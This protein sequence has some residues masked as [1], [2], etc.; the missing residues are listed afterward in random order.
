MSI[1]GIARQNMAVNNQQQAVKKMADEQEKAFGAGYLSAALFQDAGSK[2]GAPGRKMK[3]DAQDDSESAWAVAMYNMEGKAAYFNGARFSSMEDKTESGILSFGV[4]ED[5]AVYSAFYD[6]SSTIGDPVVEVRIE[7]NGER[8]L[9]TKVHVSQVNSSKASQAELFALCAYAN[10]QGLGN[11]TEQSDDY[12]NLL[13]QGKAEELGAAGADEF[14]FGKSDW[15]RPFS[16]AGLGSVLQNVKAQK[17]SPG[18]SPFEARKKASEG[19]PYS[20]LAKDGIIDYK[21]V[22]FVCDDEHRALHLGNTSDRS[23]CIQIGLS[24][25][26]SLIVNRDNIGDL[27]KAIG[28]FS[29]EDVNLILRAIAQDAKIQQMQKEIEDETSS[30]GEAQEA[31]ETDPAQETDPLETAEGLVQTDLTGKKKPEEK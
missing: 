14:V 5:G 29:P 15:S 16:K 8:F 6:P 21:G 12:R 26:G 19:A 2:T 3:T 11:D 27:A 10:A 13:Q 23:K 20:Y 1:T 17:A 30:I 31:G 9:E 25:G 18:L 7:K 22:I 4:L 24:G 28:M